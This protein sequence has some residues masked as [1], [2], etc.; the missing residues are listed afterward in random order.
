MNLPRFTVFVAHSLAGITL[1][2]LLTP[3]TFAQGANSLSVL[4]LPSSAFSRDQVFQLARLSGDETWPVKSLEN[5]EPV[6]LITAINSPREC[7]VL[8]RYRPNFDVM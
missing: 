2:A 3:S 7:G 5:P 8:S 1:L 4:G 6:Y